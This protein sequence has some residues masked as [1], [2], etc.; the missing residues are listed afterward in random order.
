MKWLEIIELDYTK[1]DKRK[2]ENQIKLLM[3]KLVSEV[4]PYSI[5]VFEHGSRKNQFLVYL[6]YD[7]SKSG[8]MVKSVGKQLISLMDESKLL[9]IAFMGD[10]T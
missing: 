2:L 10:H 8:L 3:N 4:K 6:K 7:E 5:I 1:A 9:N